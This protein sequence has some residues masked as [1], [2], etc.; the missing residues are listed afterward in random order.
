MK[1]S[2]KSA[3]QYIE[4]EQSNANNL[5]D[6]IFLDINMPIMG[7][8]EFLE[9]HHQ[10][11]K[12]YQAGLVILMMGTGISEEDNQKVKSYGA[13]HLPKPL[14]ASDFNLIL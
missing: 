10:L 14:T 3:L 5:P 13:K 6:I 12:E 11:E 7:G 1:N 4:K 2:G 8:W 9:Q